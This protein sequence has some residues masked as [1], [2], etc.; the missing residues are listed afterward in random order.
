[1]P[2]PNE[3]AC[4]IREPDEFQNDS[5]RRIRQGRLRVIIGRLIGKTK[6]TIQ[7]FRYPTSDWSESE[8]RDHC[9]DHGGRFEKASGGE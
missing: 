5:F 7:A 1:M 2:Y 8:A 4:R 6:T 9:R 3:H